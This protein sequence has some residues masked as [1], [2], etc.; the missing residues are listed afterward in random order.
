ML[1]TTQPESLLA[2]VGDCSGLS[3]AVVFQNAAT[4]ALTTGILRAATDEVSALIAAEFVAHANT[5]QA[6][7][8]QATVIHEMFVNAL[9]TS[10][11][12]YA[13][14]AANSTAAR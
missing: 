1:A 2:A 10:T 12:T 11:D 5:Y 9:I 6:M 4:A 8:A 3:S 14:E 7:S 13:A